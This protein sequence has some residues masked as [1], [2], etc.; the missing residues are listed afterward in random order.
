MTPVLPVYSSYTLPELYIS[1]SYTF[2][3]SGPDHLPLKFSWDIYF[4]KIY[5]PQL[6][7]SFL[8]P[9]M[10]FCLIYMFCRRFFFFF[11]CILFHTLP[12]DALNWLCA[13][14][15][16][17]R[18]RERGV[19]VSAIATGILLSLSISNFS[20]PPQTSYHLSSTRTPTTVADTSPPLWVQNQKTKLKPFII[21]QILNDDRSF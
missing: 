10:K 5:F 6:C 16:L 18:S 1:L 9:R 12:N 2:K 3:I 20:L 19:E 8:H 11:F 13:R 4:W 15:E 14:M 7:I 17:M 21:G